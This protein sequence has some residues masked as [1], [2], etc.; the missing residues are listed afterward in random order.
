MDL[1]RRISILKEKGFIGDFKKKALEDI[2]SEYDYWINNR[3]IVSKR[4]DE[5]L[6]MILEGHVLDETEG[7]EMICDDESKIN[8][9]RRFNELR[10]KILKDKKIT[11][12]EFNELCNMMELDSHAQKLVLEEYIK[13]GIIICK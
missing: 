7:F 11:S 12:D 6:N 10:H 5:L 2:K 1:S 9:Y 13:D 4:T 3:T 8:S